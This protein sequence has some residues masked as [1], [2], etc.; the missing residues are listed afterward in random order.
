[1]SG[2][3]LDAFQKK[4][5]HIPRLLVQ[6]LAALTKKGL[7]AVANDLPNTY[8]L[9]QEGKILSNLVF[10]RLTFLKEDLY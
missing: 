3:N 5:S 7:V 2:L 6:E 1:M 8:I 4:F 10:E 9:T